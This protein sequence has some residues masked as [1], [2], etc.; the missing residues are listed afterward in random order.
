MNNSN[1]IEVKAT[2]S[3]DTLVLGEFNTNIILDISQCPCDDEYLETMPGLLGY[4]V[5]EG[6]TL[7]GIA[8]EYCTTTDDIMEINSLTSENIVPDEMLLLVKH[9]G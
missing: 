2:V 4:R 3:L 6:D 7:F 1:E 8:K 9:L 5:K